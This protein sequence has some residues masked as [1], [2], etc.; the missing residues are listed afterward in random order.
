MAE[1]E[2]RLV[3]YIEILAGE[4]VLGICGTSARTLA[5]EQRHLSQ[6]ARP[7]DRRAPARAD[8]TRDH[9]AQ[10]R[11]P[12]RSPG[13][14]PRA[15]RRLFSM[16]HG[17]TSGRPENRTTITGLPSARARSSTASARRAAAREDPDERGSPPRR[18]WPRLR[19][20]TTGWHP[21]A[22]T[23]R[24]L[25]QCPRRSRRRCRRPAACSTSRFGK[26]AAQTRD[27][28]DMAPRARAAPHHGPR[29]SAAASASGPTTA[30]RSYATAQR[31]ASP[32]FF[33]ITMARAPTLARQ[34][35]P[36]CEGRRAFRRRRRGGTD[37]RTGPA[38]ASASAPGA[39]RHRYPSTV[40]QPRSSAVGR[41]RR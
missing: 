17:T 8:P 30:K 1:R 26:H 27:H 10:W 23:A 12:P 20:R 15:R 35:P 11:C 3:R 25:R 37:R 4:A 34:P 9:I 36:R 18:S 31:Q 16:S 14:R 6:G 7:G 29:I 32:S 28:G 24:A 22:R 33:S 39:R 5:E 19:P 13:T 38:A 21:P 40:T 2:E 41:P